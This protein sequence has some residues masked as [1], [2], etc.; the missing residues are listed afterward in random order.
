MSAPA[1]KPLA[2]PDFTI[3]P[4]GGDLASSTRCLSSSSITSLESTFA[5]VPGLS[6]VNHTMPSASR[7]S[8]QA[9]PSA[10]MSIPYRND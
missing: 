9:N 6:R 1:T 8:R 10:M 7:V 4:R 2:L 3:T 5:E